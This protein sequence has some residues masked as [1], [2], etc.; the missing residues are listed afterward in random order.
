MK[1]PGDNFPMG[2]PITPE[3]REYI[4]QIEDKANALRRENA[5]LRRHVV[6]LKAVLA[7]LGFSPQMIRNMAK[8]ERMAMRRA[9][10]VKRAEDP[11]RV[12][13]DMTVI[14]DPEPDDV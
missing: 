9:K 13:A 5:S 14:D 2:P 3:E 8:R 1:H 6:T 12:R 4:D 7:R 10:R 11:S